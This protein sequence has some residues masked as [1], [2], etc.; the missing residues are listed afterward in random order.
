ML[1]LAAISPGAEATDAE[2]ES[3]P[4]LSRCLNSLNF[5]DA[6][7]FAPQ[8]VIRKHPIVPGYDSLGR[9]GFYVFSEGSD[10]ADFHQL[11]PFGNKKP[12][13]PVIVDQDKKSTGYYFELNVGDEKIPMVYH[14]PKKPGGQVVIEEAYPGFGRLKSEIVP[15]R[16]EGTGRDSAGPRTQA[17]LVKAVESRLSKLA[18]NYRRARKKIVKKVQA[19]AAGQTPILVNEVEGLK[20]VVAAGD[21]DLARHKAKPFLSEHDLEVVRNMR[22]K[23]AKQLADKQAMIER[24]GLVSHFV[25]DQRALKSTEKLTQQAVD[26]CKVG[27]VAG[28]ARRMESEVDAALRDKVPEYK[29]ASRTEGGSSGSAR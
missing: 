1:V 13:Q 4:S 12:Y 7:E 27:P 28:L 15:A 2:P 25:A 26:A 8:T 18:E 22:D 21:Q 23:A 20:T 11:P 10:T 5:Y 17:V 6:T 3:K 19:N 14:D 9:K 29:G 16:L 24:R